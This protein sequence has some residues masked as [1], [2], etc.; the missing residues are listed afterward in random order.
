[1]EKIYKIRKN[2]SLAI[3]TALL[4]ALYNPPDKP[5]QDKNKK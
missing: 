1:M 5:T 4:V 3:T 2:Q